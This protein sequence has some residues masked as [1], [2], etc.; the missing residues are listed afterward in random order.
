MSKC[1]KSEPIH[2][3]LDASAREPG[4]RRRGNQRLKKSCSENEPNYGLSRLSPEKRVLACWLRQRTTVSL[5][6]LGERLGMGHYT[7]VSQ[8]IGMVKRIWERKL[9]RLRRKLLRLEAQ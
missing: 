8:A 5:R 4:R 9:E 7:R 2:A 3:R 1:K 6:W